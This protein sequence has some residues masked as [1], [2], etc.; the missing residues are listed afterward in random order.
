MPDP[1]WMGLGDKLTLCLAKSP[2]VALRATGGRV[3]S[4]IVHLAYVLRWP[5]CLSGGLLVC[6]TTHDTQEDP[7]GEGL[8]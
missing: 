7:N 2:G 6:Q 5:E 1:R 4:S 8:I 3:N